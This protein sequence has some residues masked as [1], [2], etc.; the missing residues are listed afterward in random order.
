M[1]VAILDPNPGDAADTLKPTSKKE[2][3]INSF[4]FFVTSS[5]LGMIKFG[6]VL[7]VIFFY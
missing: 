6:P 7:E 2:E 1:V 4:V 5:A 3:A